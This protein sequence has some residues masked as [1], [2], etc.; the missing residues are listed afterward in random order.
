M[1]AKIG[2]IGN[3]D[4]ARDLLFQ[5]NARLRRIGNA[6]HQRIDPDVSDAKEL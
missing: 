6:L 4:V 1:F 3:S 5:S 2:D